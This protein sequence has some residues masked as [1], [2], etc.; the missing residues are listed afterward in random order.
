[1][2]EYRIRETGEVMY[3]NELRRWA[4]NNNGPSW[5]QTTSE[6]LEVL[7]A[8][9]VYEGLPAEGGDRYQ[10]SMRDGVENIEGTWYTKYV[11]GP[12]FVDI[13]PTETSPGQTVEEQWENYRAVKDKEQSDIVRLE[14]NK[15]LYACDWTQLSDAPVDSAAWAAY[16]QAL[17][18]ISSQ[19]GFPW[20]ISWPVEP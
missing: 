14:R 20:E 8:D 18:D 6:V 11:L 7:G 2:P 1:M 4:K 3:E 19:P 12:I 17:R 5:D 10:Y 16:R 13:P 9:F 15:R